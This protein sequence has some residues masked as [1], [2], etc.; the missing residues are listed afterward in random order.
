MIILIEK[1][2]NL[3]ELYWSHRKVAEF[4][5]LSEPTLRKIIKWR[6]ADLKY[7]VIKKVYTQLDLQHSDECKQLLKD[8]QLQKHINYQ[9]SPT[10]LGTIFK[11]KRLDLWLSIYNVA[12][13]I[14]VHP[15]SIIRIESSETLPPYNS[16][17]IS[18]LIHVYEYSQE[19]ADM[20]RRYIVIVKDMVSIIKSYNTNNTITYK[21]KHKL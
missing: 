2:N 12:R 3:I 7:R 16:Y 15:R 11:T 9:W 10:L 18:Q 6:F 14:K 21:D 20:I 1:I 8:R 4:L 5:S 19:E 13:L 17:I